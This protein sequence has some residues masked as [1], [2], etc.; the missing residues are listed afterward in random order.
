MKIDDKNILEMDTNYNGA[1]NFICSAGGDMK[2]TAVTQLK[3]LDAKDKTVIITDPYLFQI[4]T[5]KSYGNDLKDIL[6]SLEAKTIIWCSGKSETELYNSINT[7]L[8]ANGCTL[9]HNRTLND[10]HDRFWYCVENNKAVV[11][12]TSLNGLCRKICRVDE[13]TSQEANELKSELINRNVI[14]GN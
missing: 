5:D 7:D 2:M 8:S 12:G 3:K 10:C 6:L 9:V 13:L 1:N 14:Q 11:F 4:G